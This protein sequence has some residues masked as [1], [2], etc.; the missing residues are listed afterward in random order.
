MKIIPAIDIQD[1][2]C[3]RLMQ[4]DFKRSTTYENDPYRVAINW[5]EDG[6]KTIQIIDL[7][8]ARYGRLMNI[9]VVKKIAAIPGIK[10]Q[11][12][13][14]IRNRKDI[15]LLFSWGVA[16]VILGTSVF[17]NEEEVR[18]WIGSY[19]DRIL[20]SLDSKDEIVMKRGWKSDTGERIEESMKRIR[21]WGVRECIYT[22]INRDGTLGSI[23]IDEIVRLMQM[24]GLGI[25]V[26]GGIRTLDDIMKLKEVGAAGVVIGRALYEKTVDLKE[27]LKSC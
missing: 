15:E 12:G 11:Y 5:K 20:I 3:V 26:A 17:E 9:E 24:V 19:G 18:E 1:G 10:L 13:G 23:D 14:G 25:T 8:A 7:D 22:D 4:G 27:V 16:R 2:K 21:Q 6:A